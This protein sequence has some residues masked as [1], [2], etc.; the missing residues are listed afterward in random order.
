MST[1]GMTKK[2]RMRRRRRNRRIL[3]FVVGLLIVAL[4]WIGVLFLLNYLKGDTS[5]ADT[6]DSVNTE[7][8]LDD[9][10]NEDEQEQEDESASITPAPAP[11]PSVDLSSIN[12]TEALL[13]RLSDL[14]VVAEK[15]ADQRLYPASMTK[16]MTA[17]VA[18]ENLT[19]MDQLVPVTQEEYDRLYLEGASVAGFGPGDQVKAIDMLYGVLLP[20]GAECCVGLAD[21]LF[22]SEDAMVEKMNEKAAALGMTSTHFVTSTGLHDENHYTTARDLAVLLEYA[23]QN[24][25]FRTIYCTSKYTTSPTASCPSGLTFSSTMFKKMDSAAVNGGEILGGK[26]GYTQEAGQCLA[27][28]A[29]VN[30][31]EY[32]LVTAGAPGGPSDEPYHIYDAIN[33]YNQIA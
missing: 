19:D 10:S 17:I 29:Q 12:S 6:P 32:I 11:V 15:D 33:I 4:V 25:T 7:T 27:S 28:L 24:E 22:G 13:I 18:I 30:G 14:A 8:P 5:E 23:L 20:S 2:Q 3:L 1:K 26:T 16:I 9:T 31:E 21:Q